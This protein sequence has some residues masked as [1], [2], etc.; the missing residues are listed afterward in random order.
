[1]N[2]DEHPK[3][4]NRVESRGVQPHLPKAPGAREVVRTSSLRVRARHS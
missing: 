4:G 2:I 1:M 3:I